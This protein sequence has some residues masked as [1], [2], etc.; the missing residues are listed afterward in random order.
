[1]HIHVADEP[2]TTSLHLLPPPSLHSLAANVQVF[3]L[4]RA[5]ANET[6]MAGSLVRSNSGIRAPHVLQTCYRVLELA[7]R[8]ADA[9]AL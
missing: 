5:G 6:S 4:G 2:R 7:A 1:M 8:E 3:H 9:E